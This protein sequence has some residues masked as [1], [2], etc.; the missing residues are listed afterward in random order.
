MKCCNQYSTQALDSINAQAAELYIYYP[1]SL[2]TAL[3]KYKTRRMFSKRKKKGFH[4][5]VSIG[6]DTINVI[7]NGC[8]IYVPTRLPTQ[9][10]CAAS[11]DK[12]NLKC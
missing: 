7:Y 2:P 5:N 4:S 11:W 8:E 10:K 3:I 1:F 12:G 9:I 6:R